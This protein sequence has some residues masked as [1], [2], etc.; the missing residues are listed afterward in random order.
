[1]A[2]LS[3][4]F[5]GAT[6]LGPI[7]TNIGGSGHGLIW[8]PWNPTTW[9]AIDVFGGVPVDPILGAFSYLQGVGA[10]SAVEV[11][12]G[13]Y[14]WSLFDLVWAKIIAQGITSV[15]MPLQSFPQ[16]AMV[17]NAYSFAGATVSAATPCV[18]SAP[19][20]QYQNGWRVFFTGGTLPTGLTLGGGNPPGQYYYVVSN[21]VDGAG[22]FR[23]ALTSGGAAI[24]TTGS[25]GTSTVTAGDTPPANM[26][27][28]SAW[29]TSYLTRATLDGL[30][31]KF[32]EG[33]N[34]PNNGP[35]FFVGTQAELV[36]MQQ[37]L[38]N[39]AKAFDPTIKVL[40]PP[41]NT[42]SVS[43]GQSYISNFLAAG[44]GAFFDILSCHGYPGDFPT[45]S[46]IL[47]QTNI[48]S[49]AL[50]AGRKPLWISEYSSELAT[51]PGDEIWLSS[52]AFIDW[53]AGVERKYFY[54]Y[55]S[56]SPHDVLW[57]NP[58]ASPP[59]G[60]LTVAG[61]AFQTMFSLAGS[62]IK[63]PLS[64][65]GVV[66][67]MDFVRSNGAYCRAVWTSDAS[68]PSYNVPKW[69]ANTLNLDGT[70]TSNPGQAIAIGGLPKIL[71]ETPGAK[72]SAP[73]APSEYHASIV[74][75]ARALGVKDPP[76]SPYN[77]IQ[78]EMNSV[79]VSAGMPGITGKQ[80]V[81]TLD[82]VEQ[83]KQAA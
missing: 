22:K 15:L 43:G 18:V 53:S 66:Y 14:D 50:L 57:N 6:I 62:S 76:Y 72:I 63:V 45:N 67:S 77:E 19:G 39:A 71:S 80:K 73:I 41:P 3:S 37:K 40:S 2:I 24:N 68:T 55:D 33:V 4:D 79:F 54:A 74:A 83:L 28:L 17:G 61:V 9:R 30:P 36:S 64:L 52:T 16:W 21:G 35:T 27:K 38:Y 23:L 58:V 1:M 44:G 42:P 31:I 51:P 49:V 11:S 5:F 13:T 75:K 26:S 29:V 20:N 34:E 10:W 12:D 59:I 65:N 8:P 78:G 7:E 82:V 60:S 69:A 46:Q 32:V 70:S 25:G 56:G 81:G 48:G 47:Y